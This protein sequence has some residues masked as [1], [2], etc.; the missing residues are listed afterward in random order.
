MNDELEADERLPPAVEWRDPKAPA[1]SPAAELKRAKDARGK[2]TVVHGIY[3]GAGGGGRVT[4]V[5]KQEG[6]E[7]GLGCAT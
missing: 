3:S 7:C 5:H 2:N 6:P 1:R 4:S